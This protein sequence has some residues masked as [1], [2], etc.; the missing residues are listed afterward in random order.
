MLWRE[1]V[2][3]VRTRY[4]ND[5]E[6]EWPGPR[7]LTMTTILSYHYHPPVSLPSPVEALKLLDG[8]EYQ[9]CEHEEWETSEARD[10]C[11]ALR[12]ALIHALPG[13]DDAQW[14]L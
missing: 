1:N 8:L 7:G 14:T 6:G 5:T 10:F 3:S 4:P 2:V 9:S 11:D 13:Y 12:R